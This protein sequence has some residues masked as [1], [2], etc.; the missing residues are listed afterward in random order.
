MG[1]KALAYWK[2]SIVILALV[3]TAG[4]GAL[5]APNAADLYAEKCAACHG[6]EGKGDGPAGQAMTPP[7][8]PFSTALKGKSD[9]WIGTVIV[10]GGPAVGMAPSMPPHQNLSGDQLNAL[11]QYIK[12][13]KS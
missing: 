10:K 8:A 1:K 2:S 11:I 12:G 7:P 6:D 4:S 9:D 13:L 3:V 5:A